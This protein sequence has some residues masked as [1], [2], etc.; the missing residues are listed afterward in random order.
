MWAFCKRPLKYEIVSI[1]ARKGFVNWYAID[2]DKSGWIFDSCI[3]KD[4]VIKSNVNI[5][6]LEIKWSL[7]AGAWMRL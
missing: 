3:G 4:F 7:E 1:I 2:S 6:T 5:S